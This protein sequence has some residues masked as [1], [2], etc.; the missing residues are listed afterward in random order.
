M[1]LKTVII[2]TLKHV[3]RNHPEAPKQ[4]LICTYCLP[5]I[6]ISSV[7]KSRRLLLVLSLKICVTNKPSSPKLSIILTAALTHETITFKAQMASKIIANDS[8]PKQTIYTFFSCPVIFPF[9]SIL[10]LLVFL[11]EVLDVLYTHFILCS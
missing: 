9:V 6:L 10:F 1:L 5:R 4:V 8:P 7:V 11:S 3:A 2:N